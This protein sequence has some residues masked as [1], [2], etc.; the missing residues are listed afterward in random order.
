MPSAKA[1]ALVDS[2]QGSASSQQSSPPPWSSIAA[3]SGNSSA[4]TGSIPK[5]YDAGLGPIIFAHYA[6]AMAQH[7][8]SGATSHVLETA[9]GTGIVTRAL[10]DALPATTHLTATDLNGEMMDVARAKVKAGEAVD[11]QVAD[12]TALP[13]ADASF[14][15]MICQ[16]GMMFY[17]DKDR[18]FRE[19]YRVLMPGGRYLFSVWDSHGYNPFGRITHGT[20]ASFFSEDP[21]QFYAVPFS[22]SDLNQIKEALLAAGFDSIKAS[23]LRRLQPVQDF[24][25]FARGA[26][27]GNPVLHQITQRGGASPETIRRAVAD[28]L[29]KDLGQEPTAMP[30]QMILV[31]ACKLA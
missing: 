12:G 4:F 24:G 6:I 19:A 21:P 29:R 18:G 16:F 22:Y 10:R 7:A 17:P 15:T 1:G 20:I 13:F 8:V 14:D 2:R 5:D 30:L 28:A 9:C 11:F 31:E 25:A 27:F 3:M 23:V 26:V